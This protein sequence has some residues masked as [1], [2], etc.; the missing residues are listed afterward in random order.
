MEVSRL[1]ALPVV[2]ELTDHQP[3]T[4]GWQ[5]MPYSGRRV[6]GTGT[7]TEEEFEGAGLIGLEIVAVHRKELLNLPL[8]KISGHYR[9]T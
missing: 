9:E 6:I 5:G 4:P 7:G 2:E 1:L 3:A 8:R